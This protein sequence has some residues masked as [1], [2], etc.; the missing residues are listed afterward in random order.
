MTTPRRTIVLA[1]LLAVVGLWAVVAPAPKPAP[2]AARQ[3]PL[4]NSARVWGYQLQGAR[5]DYIDPSIDLLVIDHARD[6]SGTNLLSAAGVDAFRARA[7]RSPRI[8]LAY[9]SI[10]EAETYRYYWS[11][12]WSAKTSTAARP[13]SWLARENTD[14]KGN[15]LVRF[16]DPG[17]QKLILDPQPSFIDALRRRWFSAARP[18]LDT[19]LDAGFDGVYLD[20]VDVFGEWE[21]TRPGAE[22]EMA[23]FVERLAAYAR[24]R[25]PGFLV[26]AQNGEELA[27]HAPFRQAID[28]MAKEDLLF[29]VAAAERAND[30]DETDRSI[31]FLQML[32]AD[33]KPVFV[34]EYLSDAAK[35]A[36]AVTRLGALGFLVTFAQ[37]ELNRAPEPVQPSIQPLPQPPSR[38]SPPASPKPAT[39]RPQP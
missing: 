38:P 29:G 3:G 12:S 25:K 4:L 20:R 8:V 37:R 27:A 16:W 2:L 9:M 31:E 18:Y 11:K 10:G 33:G 34:V 30:R 17:W 22:A 36:Q 14:W 15:Y 19:I 24:T 21:K 13:P 7:G 1:L 5:A 28:G 23:A 35:R 26:M 39:P 32:K 6:T